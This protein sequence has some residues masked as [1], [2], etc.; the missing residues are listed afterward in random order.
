[1][2]PHFDCARDSPTVPLLAT[3]GDPASSR[4]ALAARLRQHLADTVQRLGTG[5]ADIRHPGPQ[6]DLL[7]RASA[8]FPGH[9]HLAGELFIQLSG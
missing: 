8:Y 2:K 1:M 6:G 4:T 7:P 3:N 5:S 9:F